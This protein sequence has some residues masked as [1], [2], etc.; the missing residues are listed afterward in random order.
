MIHNTSG[1]VYHRTNLQEAAIQESL[2]QPYGN[3]KGPGY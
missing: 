3:L 1:T 2:C